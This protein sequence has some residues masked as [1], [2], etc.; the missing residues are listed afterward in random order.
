M[1]RKR[2]VG[3]VVSDKMENTVVVAVERI[4]RHPRYK[5]RMRKHKRYK[6]HDELGAKVGQVVEIEECRPMS[7]EKRFKVIRIVN[8]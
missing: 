4:F 8:N 1:S 3:T 6:A 7:K 5:K 2:L